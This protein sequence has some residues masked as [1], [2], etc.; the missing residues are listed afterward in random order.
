MQLLLQKRTSA[1]DPTHAPQSPY[2]TVP[3]NGQASDGLETDRRF[4]TTS[5]SLVIAAGQKDAIHS[6]DALS[7]L[8][9]LYWYPLYAY[10][11]RQGVDVDKAQDLTQAFFAVMLEKNYIQDA[12]RE[13][14]KFRS[15]LLACLKHFL[16]NERD[17]EMTL[18]RGGGTVPISLDMSLDDAE[19]RYALDPGHDLT[20]ERMF[21]QRWAMT[22]MKRVQER[23]ATE[24]A[25]TG[26]M[27]QFEKLRAFITE[28]A[29][30]PYREVAVEI[31]AT[32]GA[33]KVA[34]HRL[35]RR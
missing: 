27:N 32:E 29:D 30:I 11:R 17:R 24:F 4:P 34:V 15:F 26:K 21:E 31:G 2:K 6:R 22:I 25:R 5:W 16:L 10:I 13:R 8:C 12:R 9:R 14:G 33:V 3:F 18:K 20:P 23:L 28:E 35:R 7:E 1:M 19:S